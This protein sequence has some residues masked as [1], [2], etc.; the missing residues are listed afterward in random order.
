MTRRDLNSSGS[1]KLDWWKVKRTIFEW[2]RATALRFVCMQKIDKQYS[3]KTTMW[4]GEI[5]YFTHTNTRQSYLLPLTTLINLQQLIK[6]AHGTKKKPFG[7]NIFLIW[8]CGEKIQTTIK[9]F[10]S[11][12]IFGSNLRGHKAETTKVTWLW[13][14]ILILILF[15]SWLIWQRKSIIINL[16]E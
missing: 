6:S 10:V 3:H 12:L 4:V 1:S 9:V 5:F 16:V 2:A 14:C 11:S 8:S 7:P 15:S 13:H